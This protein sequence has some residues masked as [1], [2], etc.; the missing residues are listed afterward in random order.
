M[1]DNGLILTTKTDR[2]DLLTVREIA[3]LQ[4]FRD[5]FVF[6]NSEISQ[7]KDVLKA[8]PPIV[9]KQIAEIILHVIRSSRVM[10]LNDPG[11]SLRANKRARVENEGDR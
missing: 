9:A 6:Y 3:R 2:Q 1:F 10:R 4:G 11:E 8:L 7:Y 5:D